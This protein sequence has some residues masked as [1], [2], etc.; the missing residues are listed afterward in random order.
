M[1][2]H[3]HYPGRVDPQVSPKH[4]RVSLIFIGILLHAYE[5]GNHGIDTCSGL[6]TPTP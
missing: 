2:S 1:V 3:G 5:Y 4:L 6:S